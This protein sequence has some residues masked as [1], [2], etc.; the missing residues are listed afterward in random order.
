MYNLLFILKDKRKRLGPKAKRCIFF[1]YEDV[2]KEFML[3]DPIKA[4]VILCRNV[5]ETSLGFKKEQQ[6]DS[7]QDVD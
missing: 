2:T 3:Y 6:R 5:D 4:S 7:T 1:G